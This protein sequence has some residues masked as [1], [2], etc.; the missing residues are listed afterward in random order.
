MRTEPATVAT[1]LKHRMACVGCPIAPFH[2]LEDVCQEYRLES[3]AFLR[4]LSGI[5]NAE[6]E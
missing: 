3:G 5:A 2:T 4:E 6:T 1:L